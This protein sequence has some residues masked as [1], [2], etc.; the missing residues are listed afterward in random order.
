MEKRS[1]MLAHG[2]G[3][4][5]A[6]SLVEEVIAP[7]F[8]NSELARLEDAS[9]IPGSNGRFV[10]TQDSYVV[11]PRFF[12]GGDIGKLAV[13]GT[14]ND[15]LTTGAEPAALSVGLVLEEGFSIDELER[16]LVSMK[17][18]ADS[19][20][21]P[22]ITGDTKVVER[23]KC[24]GIYISTA[25]VGI[26]ERNRYLTVD[27]IEPGD[28]LVIN[29]P[30]GNH[31]AAITAARKEYSLGSDIRSDCAPLSGLMRAVLEAVPETRCARDPTRGGV[32]AVLVEISRSCGLGIELEEEAIPVEGPVS[33]LCD[34]FGMDPLLMA[35]EGKMIVV[36]P[37]KGARRCLEAMRRYPEG[38][39]A[40]VIGAVAEGKPRV[41]VR[42][43]YGTSRVVTM[44]KG[45]QL[46]RI[47]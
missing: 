24:D 3:G 2:G 47:C 26:V 4:R 35:N 21:V 19:V 23:T 16:I 39:A 31:E 22:L 45:A 28:L 17:K 44:P 9:R 29:G 13:S 10:M 11:S 34:L 8:D 36:I 32:G 25:G 27:R 1:V 15:I 6:R 7:I 41:T 37:K 33:S 5:A 38:A 40:A 42:T 46:P 43:A 30:V 12:P 20:P 18:T 14:V